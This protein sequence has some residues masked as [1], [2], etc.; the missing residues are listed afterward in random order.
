MN[1]SLFPAVPYTLTG[2]KM[3]VPVRKLLMGWPLEKAASRD[4][5]ANPDAIDFFLDYAA[6]TDDY[7]LIG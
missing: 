1:R 7:T 5:M 2:K 3:E 6:T 4:A